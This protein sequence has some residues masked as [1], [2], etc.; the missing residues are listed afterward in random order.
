MTALS[1]L[2]KHFRTSPENINSEQLKDY[3]Q[4]KAD[5]KIASPSTINQII[6]AYKILQ[7]DIL[8]KD[9]AS[10]RIKRARINKR[11]PIV[12]SRE[13][14]SQILDVTRNLKHRSILIMTYSAGLRLNEVRHLKIC[15]I[16]S[17]RMQIRVEQGKGKKDRYTLLAK[18]SLDLLRQYYKKYHP[19]DYLFPGRPTQNPISET[20]IQ[21]IFKKAI[22]Q[23]GIS[24]KAY[25]HCLRHSF[26]TH[27]LEQGTNI[28]IIQQLMGHASIRTTMI[29]LHVAVVD[30]VSVT[31]PGD[32]LNPENDEKLQ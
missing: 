26:A 19:K 7:V 20:T 14:I 11:L 12:L 30:A 21:V 22:H 32:T 15:D 2:S 29:Y 28:R 6:S 5:Q 13:E 4:H 8:G 1:V 16:D 31:S 27:L 17:D 10:F 18:S 25:F 9:W 23:A 24:K 3:L